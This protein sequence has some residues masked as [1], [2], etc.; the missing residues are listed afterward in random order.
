VNKAIRAVWT[1]VAV[2]GLVLGLSAFGGCATQV[3]KNANQWAS[4]IETAYNDAAE[5]GAVYG[6]LPTCTAISPKICSKARIVV[7][8]KVAKDSAKPVIDSAVAGL[9]DPNVGLADQQQLIAS[10]NRALETL[11]VLTNQI[12]A[13]VGKKVVNT[14]S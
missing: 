13:L 7:Q 1:T 5:T 11:T 12:A 2:I 8:I 10:A 9:R 3:P 14:P 6:E 4:A